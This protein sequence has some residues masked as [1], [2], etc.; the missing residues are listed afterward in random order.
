MKYRSWSLPAI[1]QHHWFIWLRSPSLQDAPLYARLNVESWRR[2]T[3]DQC[4]EPILVNSRNVMKCLEHLMLRELDDIRWHLAACKDGAHHH[5]SMAWFSDWQTRTL[6]KMRYDELG[7]VVKL[8]SS[9]WSQRGGFV[10]TM[11]GWYRFS[12]KSMAWNFRKRNSVYGKHG[13]LIVPTIFSSQS[14]RSD[15]SKGW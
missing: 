2:H 11:Y 3:R 12:M 5:T 14:R 10:Q 13:C 4:D 1:V 7:S 9:S 8:W 15:I 6:V